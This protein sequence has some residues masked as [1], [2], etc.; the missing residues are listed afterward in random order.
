[1]VIN[2]YLAVPSDRR[3]VCHSSMTAKTP[4]GPFSN[5]Y[6]WFLTFD[7]GGKQIVN[8]TEFVDS[9]ATKNILSKFEDAGLG[10]KH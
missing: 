1:M 8:I 5:E 3:V 4:V 7:E 10:K 2:D 6:V 9:S